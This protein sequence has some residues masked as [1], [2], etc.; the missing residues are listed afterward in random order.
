M[1]PNSISK[2]VE[3]LF[4]PDALEHFICLIKEEISVTSHGTKK[5][6][7]RFSSPRN[8]EKGNLDLGIL[9]S[10]EDPIF[11]ENSLKEFAISLSD[12]TSKFP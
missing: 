8:A 1:S 10:I 3:T 9:A 12:D 5:M 11:V 6:L 2:F 7:S 4:G